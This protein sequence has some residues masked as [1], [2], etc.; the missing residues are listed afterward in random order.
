MVNSA[1]EEED[2]SGS[3]M[4]F[5]LKE[6]TEGDISGKVGDVLLQLS[7]KPKL[8]CVGVDQAFSLHLKKVPTNHA[9]S[10]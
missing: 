10:K 3:F 4:Q 8:M 6:E 1:V 7:L 5:G 2:K 9:P